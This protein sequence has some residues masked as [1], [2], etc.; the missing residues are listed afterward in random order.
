MNKAAKFNITQF[1]FQMGETQLKLIQNINTRNFFHDP[2]HTHLIHQS[3]L[4]L[5]IGNDITV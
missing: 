4:S 1:N 5:R 2:Y 3:Y